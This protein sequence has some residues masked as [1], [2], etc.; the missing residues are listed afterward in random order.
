MPPDVDGFTGRVAELALLD[1]VPSGVVVVSGPPGAG[2]T[3]LVVHWAHR[4]AGRFPDGQLHVDLHGFDGA[5]RPRDPAE[6]VRLLLDALGTDPHRIPADPDARLA[7]Y[8]SLTAGRRMLLV[9]DNAR[10]S[11]QVRPLV[12]AGAGMRTVVTSRRRLTTLV[13]GLGAQPLEVDVLP[14]PAAVELVRR[15]LG[16]HRAG[17]DEAGPDEAGPDV[18]AEIAE[19]CGR[20]PLALTL[21][22]AR[23]RLTGT[24][25]ATL[26]AELRRPAGRLEALDD[27]GGGGLRTVFSWSYERLGPPAARLFR[28]LGLAA[29]PDI[30]PAAAA[31]LA[32]RPAPETRRRLRE[33]VD[34]GLLAERGDGRYAMPGLIHTYAGE[35]ARRQESTGDRRAALTRLTDHYTHTAYHADL[36]LNPARAPIPL[37]LAEPADGARPA[38]LDDLKAALAWLRGERE[39]LLAALRQ[40]KDEDLD[41]QAWQ[42]S[43]ALDTFLHEQGRWDDEGAAWAVALEAAAALGDGPALAYAY[44]FLAV[45]DGRRQRFETAR[46]HLH[47][48]LGLVRAAGDQAGEGECLFILSYLCWLQGDQ[49]E[50]LARARESLALFRLVDDPM[51]AGKAALAT[52]WYLAQSGEPRAALPHYRESLR[53]QQRAGDQ[54]NEAVTR[55]SLGWLQ[56]QLGDLDDAVRH[57]REGLRI[58]RRLGSPALEAQLLGHLGDVHEALGDPGTATARRR[59]AYAILA[60][61]GH[62]QAAELR[63]KLAGAP[64]A[65]GGADDP[66]PAAELGRRVRDHRLR[67]GLSQED[68]AARTGLS[69]RTVRYLESGRAGRPRPE[70]LRL[71]GDAFGL[72]GDERERWHAEA[73][74]DRGPAR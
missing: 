67:R 12:P 38:P 41:A 20:L 35:L 19:A 40:A 54:P 51:W 62:P 59:R 15:R 33:L 2:K 53:L 34:A 74:R 65:T 47:R 73:S 45:A 66:D 50:A 39:T 13:A 70:T 56:L 9:L 8:R 21:A 55:D 49:D 57:L 36:V 16:P 11:E 28:L 69:V 71:L 30:T 52:G 64:P 24:P 60:E 46:E 14:P 48:A 32:G 18:L 3:A 23:A 37:P 6:A 4:A 63:R 1:A 22:A 68:L 26:A 72:E 31:A 25:L 27:G 29:G 7:L 43:W 17:P 42:L 44:S 10:D 5:A 61:L 58:A